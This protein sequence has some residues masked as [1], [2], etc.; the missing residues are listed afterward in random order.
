MGDSEQ[1]NS[2]RVLHL[3]NGGDTS[4]RRLPTPAKGQVIYWDDEVAGFG[5]RITAG[6]VRAF[7]FDYRVK[8]SG[9]Q[10][11]QT[12]GRFPNWTTGA[13]RIEARR[14]QRL[15][16]QGDD[17]LGDLEDARAAPTVA[18][19]ISRFEQEHLSRKRPGT[20]RAYGFIIENHFRPAL[21]NLKVAD[22]TFSDVDSLHRH[23]TKVAGPY[24][25]NRLHSV[26]SKMLALSVRWGMRD[27]NPAKGVERNYEQKRR[28]YLIADELARLVKAL[29]AF[30]NQEAANIVRMLLF[31]GARSGE[32]MAMRWADVDLDRGL[33]SKPASTTKQAEDHEVPLSAPARQ[34]LSEIRDAE[35]AKHKRGLGEF[36]FPGSGTTGHFQ[37]L[38]G[39]W[40]RLCRDAGIS[41]LRIHDLRH[42][43]ASELASSGASLPLIGSLLGHANPATTA[44]YAHLFQDPQ[45]AAV[46]RVGAV[47]A[48]AG[49]EPEQTEKVK[50]FPKGGCRGRR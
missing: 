9:R 37:D 11:R 15:V 26:V 43:F 41:G 13:A 5:V 49:R 40:R 12:I 27:E 21:G 20:R 18:E 33:W 19:L 42:S 35:I 8:T 10:R 30:P 38:K 1:A 31:T 2:K 32:V 17:P 44:R 29:A 28:R 7:V 47:V 25:G 16:D 46:E 23:V 36:V 3:T 22:V 48:A 4:V 24:A 34:L 14:L 45:R 6:D 39:A 50:I